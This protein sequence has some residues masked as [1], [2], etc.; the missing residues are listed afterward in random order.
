MS[1]AS[2]LLVLFTAAPSPAATSEPIL[3][4]FHAQWCGPCRQMRPTLS[5]LAERGYPIKS[6]DIDHEPDLSEKY[7]VQ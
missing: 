3:L 1:I 5:L 2:L 4:D 6:V 7:G